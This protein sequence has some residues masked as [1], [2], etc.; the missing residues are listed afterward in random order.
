MNSGLVIS[1]DTTAQEKNITYPMDDKLY[2][3]IIK[4]CWKISDAES[5][6]LYQSYKNVVKQFGNLQRFKA[7]KYGANAARN[8]SKKKDN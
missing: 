4:K 2:K 8:T 7:T 1:V 5:M 6:D 3:K